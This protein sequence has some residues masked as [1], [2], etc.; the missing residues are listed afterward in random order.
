M[1]DGDSD[2]T[3]TAV[4][5]FDIYEI[6]GTGLIGEKIHK[7]LKE[8]VVGF[9]GTSSAM[10]LPIR[11]SVMSRPRILPADALIYFRQPF[12]SKMHTPSVI[13]LKSSYTALTCL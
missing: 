13:S 9:E 12:S 1:R 10:R 4:I 11:S 3:D 7:D 5:I 8:A 2:V 6:F